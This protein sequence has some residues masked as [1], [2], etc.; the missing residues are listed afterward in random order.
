MAT[1]NSRVAIV[2]GAS[3]GIGEA[4]VG[5]MRRRGYRVV[6]IAR[7]MPP[8]SDERGV[9]VDGDIGDPATADRVVVAATERFGR[10]D[11]LVNNAGIFRAKPFTEYDA[12]DYTAI[13][14]LDDAPFVTGE[15]LHVDGG[16]S[17]GC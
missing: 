6:A 12:A 1:E 4:T 7:S 11:T 2:T 14:F 17:A 5:A 13:L 8:S 9:T 10:V 3:R 15:V 16:R